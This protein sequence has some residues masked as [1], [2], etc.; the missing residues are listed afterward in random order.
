M[1]YHPRPIDTSKVAL[2]AEVRRLMESLGEALA[3]NAH[4]VWAEQRLAEG[5]RYGPKR[6]QENK[7]T[8]CLRPYAE[9]PEGEK[10]YDRKMAMQTI[11]AILA[12]GYRIEKA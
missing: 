3:E 1:I 10:E 12:L 11:L 9:L 5:W 4:D 6:D 7:E 2:S 8:P